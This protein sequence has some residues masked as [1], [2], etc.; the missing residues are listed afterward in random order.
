MRTR[1]PILALLFVI[2]AGAG[3]FA[4]IQSQV[5]ITITHPVRGPAVEA[6]YATGEVK[7]VRWA[8]VGP[9]STARTPG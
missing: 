5:S 3:V 9:K 7:P 6:V 4:Y 8:K 2:L 1:Y